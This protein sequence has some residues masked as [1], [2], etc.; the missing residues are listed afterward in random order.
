MLFQ[1]IFSVLI[2]WFIANFF[3]LILIF[4]SI[5]I[6]YAFYI[7]IKRQINR[8]VRKE[9]LNKTTARNLSRIIKYLIILII[10]SAVFFQFAESLGLV[11]ALFSLAGGTIIGFATMNTLGNAIA[12]L[13]IMISR[14][15]TVGDRILYNNEIV[16]IVDIK[17]IFTLLVDLNGIRISVPNQK[18]LTNDIIDLGKDNTIRRV[19]TVTPSFDEDRNKVEAV[20][21]K[22]AKTIPEVLSDPEPY[23]WIKT[24]QSY[25]VEYNLFVFINDLKNLPL[26]E[27]NLHKAVLDHCKENQ[28]DI[29]TPMLIQ[30]IDNDFSK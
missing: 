30:K 8:L 5:I 11:T 25:A 2:S 13:I 23:V 1:D 17:L 21:L 18:L 29:R 24:F 20:L 6:G 10:L 4:L 9:K 14:P 16:D 28:I 7:I 26:I 3:N 15:F 12:G 19:I 22:A 27:S